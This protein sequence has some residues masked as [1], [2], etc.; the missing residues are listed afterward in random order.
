MS[1]APSSQLP[2]SS[3][4]PSPLSELNRGPFSAR[5]WQSARE[6]KWLYLVAGVLIGMLLLAICQRG[7]W[8][9][10]YATPLSPYERTGDPI[11]IGRTLNYPARAL[12]NYPVYPSGD[13]GQVMPFVNRTRVDKIVTEAFFY[14][15]N[16]GRPLIPGVGI[17]AHEF[18]FE[19]E[20]YVASR[21]CWAREIDNLKLPAGAESRV[22]VRIVDPKF[23][24]Q[25]RYG[26][27]VLRCAD[28]DIIQFESTQVIVQGH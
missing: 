9:S 7:L 1:S 4:L 20:H 23:T 6:R 10:S 28:G 12:N 18:R 3:A 16:A 11:L 5:F 8:R 19:P 27:L 15:K 13:G 24:G 22:V 25:R 2:N 21:H 17:P 26:T 14:E